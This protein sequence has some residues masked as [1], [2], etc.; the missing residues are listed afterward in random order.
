MRISNYQAR[1][2]N[3]R[4]GRSGK[5]PEEEMTEKERKVI[6]RLATKLRT[7]KVLLMCS[8]IFLCFLVAPSP[9]VERLI[10]SLWRVSGCLS[11]CISQRDHPPPPPPPEII[12]SQKFQNQNL[13]Q[14]ILSNL[15]GGDP[16]P[17]PVKGK[18]FDTRF[19]LIHVQTGKKIFLHP[20]HRIS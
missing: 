6:V 3:L 1:L 14:L 20:V 7:M 5:E 10:W 13:F 4:N 19:G 2:K 11:V 9:R 18:F 8:F 17:P 16:P 12:G 15:Y